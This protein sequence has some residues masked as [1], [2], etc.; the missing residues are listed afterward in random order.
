[1]KVQKGAAILLAFVVSMAG[2]AGCSDANGQT[3]IVKESV[4]QLGTIQV[5]AREE[6]SG[7]RNVF[8]ESIGFQDKTTGRDLTTESA[9]IAN[10][11]ET[12]KELVSAD[13]NAIGYL[14]EGLLSDED[15]KQMH[16]VTV[17]GKELERNFYLAYSGKLSELGQEFLTYVKGAGQEF[18][19]ESFSPIGKTKDFLSLKPNGTL[20]IGGSTSMYDLLKQLAEDYMKQNPNAKIEVTATDSTNGL[21][22]AMSGIY[23]LGMS[24]R[25][26]K[27]Y[28]K[29]LLSSEVIAKDKIAVVVNAANPLENISSKDLKDIYTGE[30]TEWKKWIKEKGDE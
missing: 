24:S 15:Q 9:E 6:G 12:V 3:T 25:D 26:L 23:D 20:K 10:D 30:V 7:T 2:L 18:V 19:K 8:A 14:S 11:S 5:I 17:D 29:E 27:D 4:E 21:T 22:G 1:M 16:T 13:K 28:E